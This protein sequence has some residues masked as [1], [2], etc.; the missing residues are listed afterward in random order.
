MFSCPLNYISLRLGNM[1][2]FC[3][4]PK[5]QDTVSVSFSYFAKI[6]EIAVVVMSRQNS[7]PYFWFILF[8]S[9]LLEPEHRSKA[10][11]Y[12]S[13]WL[14]V[15]DSLFHS[16]RKLLTCILHYVRDVFLLQRGLCSSV[17]SVGY[18]STSPFLIPLNHS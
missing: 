16:L 17:S 18:N 9:F 1:S 2:H 14:H 6:R 8:W 5:N 13:K 10:S 12:I 15:S 7:F 11:F 4:S 3:L